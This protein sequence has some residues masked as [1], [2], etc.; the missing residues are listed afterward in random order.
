MRTVWK[1]HVPIQDE[2]TIET[3]DGADIVH[4]ALQNGECY[5]WAVV[6][7]SNGIV[8]RK[9]SIC[10]TGHPL[11]PGLFYLGS[12]QKNGFNWHVFERQ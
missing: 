2:V 11:E 5:V 12:F 8:D 1:F 3:P 10:G 9:L 4:V 6:E 7:S